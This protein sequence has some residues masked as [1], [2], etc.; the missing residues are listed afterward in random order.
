MQEEQWN[1]PAEIVA[2]AGEVDA[3]LISMTTHGEGSIRELLLGSTC[4]EVTSVSDHAVGWSGKSLSI[5]A[6]L[7]VARAELLWEVCSGSVGRSN[8]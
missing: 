7:V 3:V 6:D 8:G 2:T 1:V 5:D 4:N